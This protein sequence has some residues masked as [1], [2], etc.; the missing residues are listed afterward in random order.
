M[1]I[2]T[3]D[4]FEDTFIISDYA[5]FVELVINN[6]DGEINLRHSYAILN[7]GKKKISFQVLKDSGTITNIQLIR[8][9]EIERMKSEYPARD[10]TWWIGDNLYY[11]HI[12]IFPGG[13]V[14]VFV[15]GILNK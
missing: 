1:K 3:N 15:R 8:K 5:S 13:T 2:I 6:K 12:S 10:Y 11:R 4:Q 14:N 7:Q 9:E